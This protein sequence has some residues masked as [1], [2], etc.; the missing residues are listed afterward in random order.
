MI[1]L[2]PELARVP[3]APGWYDDAYGNPV[4][5]LC[6]CLHRYGPFV[7]PNLGTK[8]PVYP[9]V[10]LGHIDGTW[11]CLGVS[12]NARALICYGHRCVHVAASLITGV[13]SV[14]G[15]A[16]CILW[17]QASQRVRRFVTGIGMSV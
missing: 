2:P 7:P 11:T 15:I 14:A 6:L 17:Y 5:I 12:R 13:Q 8:L 1:G 9:C 10:A 16:V 4:L 3:K